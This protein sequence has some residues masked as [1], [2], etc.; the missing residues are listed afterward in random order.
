MSLFDASIF[1]ILAVFGSP[2]TAEQIRD[3]EVAIRA[4]VAETASKRNASFY[5]GGH[6]EESGEEMLAAAKRLNDVVRIL[7]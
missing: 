6:H 2:P 7:D 3:R 4:E 5:S 1:N